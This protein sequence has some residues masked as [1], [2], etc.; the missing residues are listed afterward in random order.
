MNCLAS[1]PTKQPS[2]NEVVKKDVWETRVMM[3]RLATGRGISLSSSVSSYPL[4]D[5]S[6]CGFT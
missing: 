3:M 1:T 5:I 6:F 2:G 4:F